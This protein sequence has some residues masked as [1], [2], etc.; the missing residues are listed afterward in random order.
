MIWPQHIGRNS[1]RTESKK[2]PP[3][4]G[5]RSRAGGGRCSAMDVRA[6]QWWRVARGQ[7]CGDW[8]AGLL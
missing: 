5:L 8:E 1:H 3:K 6:V 4:R 2:A 7:S